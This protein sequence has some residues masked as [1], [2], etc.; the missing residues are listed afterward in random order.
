MEQ[1]TDHHTEM[2]DEIKETDSGTGTARKHIPSR[3]MT[4]DIIKV[5]KPTPASKYRA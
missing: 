3:Q 2:T 4:N 5:N 1:G